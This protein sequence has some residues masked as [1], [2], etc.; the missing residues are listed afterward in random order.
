[1][2]K[3][4]S[5]A[6]NYHISVVGSVL[7]SNKAGHEVRIEDDTENTGGYLI[8]ERWSG[9][10]GPN[11]EGWFDSWVPDESSLK[12]FFIDNGWQIRWN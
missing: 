4:A 2:T 10:D 5:R 12:Q 11:G 1:M 6:D 9:S 3:Y 7:N 8:F